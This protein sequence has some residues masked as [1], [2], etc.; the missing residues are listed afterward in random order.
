MLSIILDP[1][2]MDRANY[3]IDFVVTATDGSGV[4][5]ESESR[6]IGPTPSR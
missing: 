6:F 2:A 3:E 1:R 4:E 5:A